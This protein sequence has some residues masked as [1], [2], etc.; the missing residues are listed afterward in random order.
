[1]LL[2]YEMPRE[3]QSISVLQLKKLYLMFLNY[4]QTQRARKISMR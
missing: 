3:K 2:Q 1:M 4:K